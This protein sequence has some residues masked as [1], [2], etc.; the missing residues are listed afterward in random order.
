MF[1]AFNVVFSL[2][3]ANIVFA[4]NLAKLC[5]LSADSKLIRGLVYVLPA[6][7]AIF[8]HDLGELVSYSGI[9]T[10]AINFCLGPIGY[11]QS[12]RLL[13]TKT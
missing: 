10:V 2:P 9:M 8:M 1:P 5:G 4:A 12:Y 7:L 11:I 13:P 6:L 3:L